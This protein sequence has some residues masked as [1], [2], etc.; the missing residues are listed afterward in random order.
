MSYPLQYPHQGG[1]GY[2]AT[3][4]AGY[5]PP[6]HQ[7]PYPQGPVPGYPPA[8]QVPYQQAGATPYPPAGGYP[9]GQPAGAMPYPQ[10][11]PAGASPYPQGPPAGAAPGG[12]DAPAFKGETPAEDVKDDPSMKAPAPSAPTL[13]QMGHVSGYENT[14]FNEAALPPPS[15]DEATRG[16][17]PERREFTNAPTITEEQAREALL[18]H[19]AEHCCYGKGAARDMTFRELTSSSAF[20]YT[21][22]TFTE[23][24]STCWAYE[25]FRGQDIDGPERGPAPGPW[26]IQATAPNLFRSS[27]LDVEVPHTA[28]VKPCHNCFSQGYTRCFRCQGRG[29]LFCHSCNGTGRERVFE[30]HIDHHHDH[31]HGHHD[32]HHHHHNHHGGHASYR[33][34]TWCH[35]SGRKRCYTCNG[36]GQVECSVCRSRGSLKCYIKLTIMWNN[37]LKDHIV[38]RTALPDHLIRTV[39]GQVAFEEQQLRV[40]PINHFPDQEVNNASK[41]IV[42]EQSR[43]YP[44]E[45]ILMQRHRVRIV[46]VTMAYYTHDDKP[47]SFF[48]YGFEHK[49]YAPD[50]PQ[51]CCCGC[52][53]L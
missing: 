45:R 15:Y 43:A 46:P 9:H 18:Q 28:S 16:P 39:S 21:L 3:P 13:D 50:Y 32:H 25:P 20:H 12:A 4:G 19:V 35:G 41:A 34:C 30:S 29:R 52:T 37:H 51:Q 14:G 33:P 53:I 11:A 36:F 27:K 7:Q 48:V 2:A 26:D 8:G 5:P 44:T 17:P 40:W 42:A 31:H 23:S 10:G 38:E 24:R 22:E 47:G 1:Q 6:Q 49:V